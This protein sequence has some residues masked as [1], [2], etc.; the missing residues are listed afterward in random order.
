VSRFI[1]KSSRNKGFSV[2]VVGMVTM[3]ERE[4]VRFKLQERIDA[5]KTQAER[6]RFGQF[7]TPP[8]LASDIV[9]YA[10]SLLPSQSKIRFLEP[11]FG[12][13]PFYSALLRQVPSS[14]IEFSV[15]YEID[16]RMGMGRKF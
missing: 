7:S 14:R 8:N 13:G 10:I 15:G 12:T 11:G 16:P 6:N 3:E 5:V 9:A 1:S 4:K 2:R